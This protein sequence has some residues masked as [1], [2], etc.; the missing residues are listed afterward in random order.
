MTHDTA[1]A[2]AI[3]PSTADLV[4]PMACVVWP[5]EADRR[6]ELTAAGVPRLL[7]VEPGELPPDQWE[8]DEDWIRVGDPVEDVALRAATLRRRLRDLPRSGG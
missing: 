8:L 5:S 2:S 7:F 1:L 6:A 3:P 4:A